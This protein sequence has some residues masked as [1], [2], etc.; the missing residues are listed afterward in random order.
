MSYAMRKAKEACQGVTS[1]SDVDFLVDRIGKSEVLND[2]EK[3][4]LQSV[5]LP[6]AERLATFYC[7]WRDQQSQ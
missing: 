6:N 5:W 2:A 3:E 7:G 4:E 1:F